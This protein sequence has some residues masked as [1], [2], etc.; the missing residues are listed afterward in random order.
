MSDCPHQLFEEK[1]TPLMFNCKCVTNKHWSCIKQLQ[2]SISMKC[3]FGEAP[4]GGEATVFDMSVNASCI[5]SCHSSAVA[6]F[7][8]NDNARRDVEHCPAGPPKVHVGLLLLVFRPAGPRYTG[9]P[10]KASGGTHLTLQASFSRHARP[11]KHGCMHAH[12]R[13]SWCMCNPCGHT[14]HGVGPENIRFKTLKL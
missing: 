10:R 14:L 5:H 9:L 3:I 13:T 12:F 4:V 11:R 6:P 2:Q 8:V 7:R 1:Q